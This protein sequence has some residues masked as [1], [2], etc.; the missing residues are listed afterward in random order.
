M[1]NLSSDSELAIGT[2]LAFVIR[3][4]V[5]CRKTRF[6]DATPDMLQDDVKVRFQVW[7]NWVSSKLYGS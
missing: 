5:E 1:G 6:L 7:K 4:L 3:P 2:E